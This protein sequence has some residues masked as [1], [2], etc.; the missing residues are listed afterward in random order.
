MVLGDLLTNAIK[1]FHMFQEISFRDDFDFRERMMQRFAAAASRARHFR[2]RERQRSSGFGPSQVLVF[3]DPSNVPDIHEVY[4][5]SSEDGSSECDS[6]WSRTISVQD[7][8]IVSS[9]TEA[10]SDGTLDCESPNNRR[11]KPFK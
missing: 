7:P 11:Y 10:A 4:T 3:P 1:C 9:P 5:S 8:P 2:R 6:P